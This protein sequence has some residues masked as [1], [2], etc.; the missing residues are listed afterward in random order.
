MQEREVSLRELLHFLPRQ[1]EA[2]IAADSH[3]YTLYGGAAGPGKSYWLRWYPVRKLIR[4]GIEYGLTGIHGALF[5]KDYPTLKDRQLSK[6]EIEF[7]RWL[8]DIRSSQT[9]GLAFHLKP[10]Y[11]GHVLA[12]RNLD[13]PSKYLSSEFAVIALEELTENDVEVFQ[14]IRG[15]LRWTGIEDVRLIAATNPGGIGH[16][17]VKQLWVDRD[18]TGEF[19]SLAPYADQFAYV[20]ALPS[21]NPYLAKSYM[22]MLNS[23]PEK[24]RKAYRDGNWDVFEGQYFPEWDKG[25]HVCKPF[26]IPATWLRYR[27]IDPS[28]RNGTT[29]CHWYA[30]NPD[31][32]VFVYREYYAT[33]RDIDEHAQ[34]ID[35]L[36]RDKDGVDEGYQYTVIDTAA[37][38]KAGYSETTAEIFERNGV[39]GLIPAAKERVVG[40]NSVHTYLRW[41]ISTPPQ[42]QIFDTCV[43]M[44][45]TIP[46]LIHDEHHPEDVD[47]RGEDHAADEL[48]YLLRTLREVKAPAAETP[49]QRRL[50]TLRQQGSGQAFDYQ[51]RRK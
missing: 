19:E 39:T 44:I 36:S 1:E 26:Q 38:A 24:L 47:S 43:N 9:D 8:G 5:S 13:D 17:W 15:R 20:R 7:P 28:G 22:D 4:W 25:Q 42:L 6:M 35:R 30:V 2:T 49:V 32:K 33:G 16:A 23:L 41:D 50:K 29:S 18:F 11:G 27:A 3:T 31:G 34:E 45:R 12:L 46:L 48:R 14:K 37:F 51:Y 10:R 40:W 21:D